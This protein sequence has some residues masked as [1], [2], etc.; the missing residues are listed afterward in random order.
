MIKCINPEFGRARAQ[1]STSQIEQCTCH[2][3]RENQANKY[4]N[5]SDYN[6]GGRHECTASRHVG[7]GDISIHGA[8]A[9]HRNKIRKSYCNSQRMIYPVRAKGEKPQR[10]RAGPKNE[11]QLTFWLWEKRKTLANTLQCSPI[12]ITVFCSFPT[13]ILFLA[14]H[15]QEFISPPKPF[16]YYQ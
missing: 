14:L 6:N 1:A 3:R 10:S 9:I 4:F 5:S 8:D 7:S 11:Q 16:Q 15:T 2:S 13:S 12:C